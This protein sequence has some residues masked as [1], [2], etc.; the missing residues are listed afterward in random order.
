MKD[1]QEIYFS[2]D[3][4]TDGQIPGEYSML[5]FGCAAFMAD[6]RKANSYKLL[7]TFYANLE[8]LPGAKENPGT[9]A[10]W[11]KNK[12][13]YDLTRTDQQ[14]PYGAM[15]DYVKWVNKVCADNNAK[16]VCVCYPAG[17]DWTFFYWYLIKFANESPF[18]FSCLDIKSFAMAKLGT[19]YRE[20]TKRNFPKSWFPDAK[21]THH[22]LDDAIE[23]GLIFCN[24]LNWDGN[25]K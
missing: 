22:A 20:T 24:I 2:L 11:E 21:H 6:D 5:S 15:R 4:E 8:T 23:Q 25:K 13:A 9:M 17:F 3:I 18:S 19:K 14:N 12:Q 10:F 16:P 1:T 7:D